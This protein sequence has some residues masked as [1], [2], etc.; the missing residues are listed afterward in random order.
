M[1]RIVSSAWWC[2]EPETRTVRTTRRRVVLH[3]VRG[4]D[5]LIEGVLDV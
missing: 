2:Q 1:P 4:E 3:F 5:N